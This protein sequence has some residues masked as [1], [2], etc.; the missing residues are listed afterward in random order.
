MN[1]KK[2]LIT[3][4]IIFLLCIAIYYSVKGAVHLLAFAGISLLVLVIIGLVIW[5]FVKRGGSDEP[6]A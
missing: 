5:L 1:F 4:A 6:R 2:I 3:L